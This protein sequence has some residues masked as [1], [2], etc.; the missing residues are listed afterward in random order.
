MIAKRD[1]WLTE[2]WGR[3]CYQVNIDSQGE[4]WEEVKSQNPGVF[5]FAKVDPKALMHVAILQESGFYLV[6]TNVQ[7]K[8]TGTDYPDL[9]E[10]DG[11]E[12]RDAV[13]TEAKLLSQQAGKSFEFS[14]FHL[15]PR[16]PDDMADRIKSE[17]VL[18]YFKGQRGDQMVVAL[19]RGKPA[20][21]VQ[22]LIRDTIWTIDLIAVFPEFRK[23]GIAKR[24]ILFCCKR[25]R[26]LD[27][28][29]VGT[30]LVNL[31][32]IGLYESCGYRFHSAQYI[33]H[34]HK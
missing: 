24:M 14:R 9:P 31:P 20:G 18:N 34:Y 21:F 28:G 10:L 5:A 12:I 23:L 15:D 25:F 13:E 26:D 29:L 19:Y 1:T 17:W 22:L 11:L 6:D 7:L 27:H 3:P 4:P 8:Y 2:L 33:F 32:S 30:Q 16:F